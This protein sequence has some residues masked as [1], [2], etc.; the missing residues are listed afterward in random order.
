[1]GSHW[2]VGGVSVLLDEESCSEG[3]WWL[4]NNGCADTT[5]L[6]TW[7]WSRW[8]ILLYVFY[9]IKRSLTKKLQSESCL[10]IVTP[11]ARRK[12][13]N[14]FNVLKEQNRQPGVVCPVP[15]FQKQG[16][17]WRY[18]WSREAVCH[19]QTP[20]ECLTDV[21]EKGKLAQEDALRYKKEEGLNK[22]V[23]MLQI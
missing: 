17:E 12:W 11:E 7:K 19:K 15:T 4:H 3:G 9:H 13:K 10:L 23:N 1:M 21:L 14:S 8:W 6:Y 20:T 16:W 5:E 2:F 22:I 18:L